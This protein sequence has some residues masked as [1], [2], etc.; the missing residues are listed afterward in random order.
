MLAKRCT[1]RLIQDWLTILYLLKR[2]LYL[3]LETLLE[4]QLIKRAERHD[5]MQQM[6]RMQA[7]R[8]N[9][10]RV[11]QAEQDNFL[12]MRGTLFCRLNDGFALWLQWLHLLRIHNNWLLKLFDW[13]RW[14]TT[15]SANSLRLGGELRESS[16]RLQL[17]AIVFHR[18]WHELLLLALLL[19][20][21]LLRHLLLLIAGSFHRELDLTGRDLLV[22]SAT[23]LCCGRCVY[24]IGRFLRHYISIRM[25]LPSA[26]LELMMRCKLIH[27]LHRV[28][29][30][31]LAQ[32]WRHLVQ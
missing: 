31:R 27:G 25:G 1:N 18:R 19:A 30:G 7:P 22:R 10:F 12:T 16:R 6:S 28:H 14:R 24:L 11:L 2:C 5:W 8:A 23:L 21:W 9:L 3:L 29:V 15:W 4:I 20:T 13:L 26:E 32:Q 17:V